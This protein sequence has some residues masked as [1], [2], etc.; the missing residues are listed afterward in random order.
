M[1]RSKFEIEPPFC[2][3]QGGEEGSPVVRGMKEEEVEEDPIE[4]KTSRSSKDRFKSFKVDL[5][6]KYCSIIAMLSKPQSKAFQCWERN[7]L[8]GRQC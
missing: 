1:F 3:F 5:G 6:I 7:S 4:S 2:R 8:L